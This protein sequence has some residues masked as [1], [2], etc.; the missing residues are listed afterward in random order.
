M[1]I[2]EKVYYTY[3]KFVNFYYKNIIYFK[4]ISIVVFFINL[5][6]ILNSNNSITKSL[7]IISMILILLTFFIKDNYQKKIK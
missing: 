3:L 6:V 1:K 4:C 2:L 7:S 5:W